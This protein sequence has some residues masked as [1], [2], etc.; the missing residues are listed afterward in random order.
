MAAPQGQP[1]TI[2]NATCIIPTLIIT[3]I[4]LSFLLLN[5]LCKVGIL[6]YLLLFPI[7][8]KGH[9]EITQILPQF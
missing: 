4:S 6:S 7:A 1:P 5:K 8:Y 2:A 9:P 3:F